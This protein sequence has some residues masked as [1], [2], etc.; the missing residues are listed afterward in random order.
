M[1]TFSLPVRTPTAAFSLPVRTA[2]NFGALL[3]SES[4][5]CSDS[6]RCSG[7]AGPRFPWNF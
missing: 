7:S 2:L 1:L 5:H 4:L 6:L 3:C